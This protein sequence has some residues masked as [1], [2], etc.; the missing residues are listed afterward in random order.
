M[1]IAVAS[2]GQ[3]RPAAPNNSLANRAL[4]RRVEIALA[5]AKLDMGTIEVKPAELTPRQ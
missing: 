4:N 5:P 2:F 1:L 3:A